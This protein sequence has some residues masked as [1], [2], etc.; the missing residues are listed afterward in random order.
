MNGNHTLRQ[1]QGER[2]SLLKLITPPFVLSLSKH[3]N[4]SG[5]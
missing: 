2:D 1:A 4:G 5:D 3:V